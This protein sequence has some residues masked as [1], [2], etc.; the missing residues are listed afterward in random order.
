MS[1]DY[2]AP[3]AQ[4][5]ELRGSSLGL[6]A[7]GTALKVEVSDCITG[8]TFGG[9][10][11]TLVSS[12]F[13]NLY[14]GDR[15][16]IVKLHEFAYGAFTYN[17]TNHGAVAFSAWTAGSVA[18]FS[19]VASGSTPGDLIKVFVNAQVT[20]PVTTTPIAYAFTDIAAGTTSTLGQGAV[21]TAVPLSAV[22]KAAPNYAGANSVTGGVA[23][24][25]YL[26]TNT[27]GSGNMSFTI[28]C[29]STVT[30]TTP[31]F[32]CPNSD[33][34]GDEQDVAIS[35]SMVPDLYS[36]CK[37]AATPLTVANA[38]S[39]FSGTPVFTGQ[40]VTAVPST[41]SAT[42]GGVSP[43][44]IGPAGTDNYANA[45]ITNGGFDT[46]TLLTG[47]TPIY[48]GGSS[49]WANGYQYLNDILIIRRR[50][51]A[52]NNLSYLYYCINIAAITQT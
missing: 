9:S 50:D 17:D 10:T 15:G 6:V 1:L 35:Y 41:L 36:T 20:S 46:I 4:N 43:G 44:Q 37:T 2:V 42:S 3:Q 28:A 21:S 45:N 13:V 30:G 25:R 22:G 11:G 40:V 34:L 23:F 26:S 27:D 19:K 33:A 18:T 48:S 38:E 47:A 39:I 14:N 49:D 31:D 24:A 52:A 7:T 16:C 12:G 51:A 5:L 32:T 29:A 8:Y